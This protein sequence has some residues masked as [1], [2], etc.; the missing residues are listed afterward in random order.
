MARE[1]VFTKMVSKADWPCVMPPP[2]RL[3]KLFRLCTPP[4][5]AT[6]IETGG[7]LPPG[8]SESERE[9]V[10]NVVPEQVHPAPP[11]AVAVTP[12]GSN[13]VIVIRP[14]LASVPTLLTVAE[15]VPV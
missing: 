3:A 1:G 10:M 12:A 6:V 15:I 8:A 14:A 2:V 13:S 7:K 11:A 4:G 9:Q 5:T